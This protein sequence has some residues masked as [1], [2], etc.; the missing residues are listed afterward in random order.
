MNKKLSITLLLSLVGS[1]SV[2]SGCNTTN[3]VVPGTDPEPSK[4]T[5]PTDPVDPSDPVDPVD[6]VDP[7]PSGPVKKIVA[8]HTLSD[9][10]PPINVSSKGQQVSED[11]WNSYRYAADSKYYANYNFTY[12]TSTAGNQ[13][14][15][16]NGY[17]ID[18][19]AGKIYYE[20]TS[21]NKF[22]TYTSAKEG[23]LRSE[24]TL[25]LNTK[26]VDVIK[27]EIYVHMF[28]FKDYEYNSSTGM[29]QN[30]EGIFV[31]KVKFQGGY[32]TYLYYQLYAYT[33]EIGKT[34][35]TTITIPESY[36]Y[37]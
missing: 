19:F 4:P 9:S 5:E 16:K 2:L 32:L 31:S 15:T 13:Y 8:A 36:Y 33:F 34:F 10:N 23:W 11:T 35:Q 30:K 26:I 1:L 25:D 29:Y 20:R 6:P 18:S 21:G 24:T 22:Y 17:F 7:P 27:Q 37:E 14:F 28:D 3:N 12:T